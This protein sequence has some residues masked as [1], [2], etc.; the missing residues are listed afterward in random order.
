VAGAIIVI[1]TVVAIMV[2]ASAVAI[3]ISVAMI[4]ICGVRRSDDCSD[5]CDGGEK[6]EKG[7]HGGIPE[8][9]PGQQLGRRTNL[10]PNVWPK[11]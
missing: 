8:R 2:V 7:L 3:G 11:G 1:P 4:V 9:R 10:H 6:G 5:Q